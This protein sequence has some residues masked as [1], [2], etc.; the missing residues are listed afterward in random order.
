MSLEDLITQ[1]DKHGLRSLKHVQVPNWFWSKIR[2]EE[3]RKGVPNQDVKA[4]T[5]PSRNPD[6]MSNREPTKYLGKKK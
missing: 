3:G 2:V 6:K 5:K 4:D 1:I